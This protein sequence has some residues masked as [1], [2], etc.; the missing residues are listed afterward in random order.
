MQ[1]KIKQ[2]I[3]HWTSGLSWKILDKIFIMSMLSI[4]TLT[5][6]EISEM[7]DVCLIYYFTS[8]LLFVVY[9]INYIHTSK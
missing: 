2:W 8:R 5:Y 4:F 6:I 1:I 3:I 9:F 7:S